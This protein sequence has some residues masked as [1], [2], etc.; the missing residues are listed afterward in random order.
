MSLLKNIFIHCSNT[1]WGEAL[2]IDQWHK[3]RGWDGIGYHH[4]VLNGRPFADVDYWDFLDGQIEAGRHLDSDPIFSSDEIGAHVAGRNPDS[5]GICLIGKREFTNKQLFTARALSL[6]LV[7][8]FSLGVKDILGHYEDPNT[9]KTCPNLPMSAFRA[10]LEYDI[11]VDELQQCIKEQE[12]VNWEA[13]ATKT[14]VDWYNQRSRT[15][16]EV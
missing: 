7:T 6:S 5:L 4:V 8:H 11:C 10:F 13:L 16:N 15:A 14:E 9:H 2:I 1:P 12:A 3:A